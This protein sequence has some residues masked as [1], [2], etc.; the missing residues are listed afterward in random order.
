MEK[1]PLLIH[2]KPITDQGGE[3]NVGMKHR[4]R[5]FQLTSNFRYCSKGKNASSCARAGYSD[6]AIQQLRN[7]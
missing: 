7:R 2:G 6:G 1:L 5:L 4:L 3:D